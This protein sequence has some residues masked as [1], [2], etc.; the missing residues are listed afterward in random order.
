MQ[1][2]IL[3]SAMNGMTICP[4]LVWCCHMYGIQLC[5][6]VC[7]HYLYIYVFWYFT[8]DFVQS[9]MCLKL[10]MS[11]VYI[12]VLLAFLFLSLS[13][14]PH[15]HPSIHPF[16]LPSSLLPRSRVSA[17]LPAAASPGARG[18]AGPELRR[19]AP[20][21][22]RLRPGVHGVPGHGRVRPPL[23]RRHPQGPDGV[24]DQEAAR[25]GGH[26]VWQGPHLS[27]GQVC[28]QDPQETLLG[29]T[30]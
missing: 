17:G 1:Y 10:C 29:K 6:C 19:C 24:P 15:T 18:A 27:A 26:P 30:G 4:G 7:V 12:R 8:G 9:K 2:F 21:P 16:I 22:A 3:H 14:L 5:V 25:R 23:V 20:V 13:I 28:G 11:H